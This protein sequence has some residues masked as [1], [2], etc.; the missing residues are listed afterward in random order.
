MLPARGVAEDL[1]WSPDGRRIA[2]ASGGSIYITT[3]AN[4]QTRR[5]TYGEATY[6]VM[7]GPGA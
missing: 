7:I 1:A 2:Y 4:R 6:A 5:L 3:V